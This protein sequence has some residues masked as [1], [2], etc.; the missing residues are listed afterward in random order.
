METV[1]QNGRF[2]LLSSKFLSIY[3]FYSLCLR[4]TQGH[5]RSFQTSYYITQ[6]L[7]ATQEHKHIYQTIYYSVSKCHTTVAIYQA[8]NR[9]LPYTEVGSQHEYFNK[10]QLLYTV[11]KVVF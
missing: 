9:S 3:I 5:K 2:T 1:Q 4:A 11:I 7:N 8:L 10:V 6:A